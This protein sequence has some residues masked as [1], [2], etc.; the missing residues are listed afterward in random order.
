MI[1]SIL[2]ISSNFTGHGHKSIAESLCEK[3]SNNPNVEVHI[4]DGFSLGGTTL[5]NV[6]K[7]YG[8]ITRKSESL[9]ELIWDI[10]SVKPYL[11]NEI[12]ELKIK[13]RFLELLRNTKPD[14]ILSLHPNFN[15]SIVNILKKYH[16]KIPFVTLIADL[17]TISPL[18][19]DSR[20]DYIISPTTEAKDKCIEFGVP[21]EKIKVLGF[22]VRSRF[23]DHTYEAGDNKRLSSDSTLKCMIMSGGEGVGNMKKIAEILLNNFDCTVKIVAGRNKV[24]K[25]KLEKSLGTKYGNRVEIYGFTKNVQDLMECSD[26]AFTRGSPNVIMEAIACNVPLVITGALPG[27][28]EENPNFVEK[29]NL[30]VIC[31]DTGK[32]KDVISELTE[33]NL[34][35]LN[36]IR[37]FQRTY[38]NP[39]AAGNI[40]NFVLNLA[41]NADRLEARSEELLFLK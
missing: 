14:V 16:I 20:V 9:W 5:L 2:V 8:P 24:L 21:E 3:F 12:I 19:A 6:A 30:G 10:S 18:W 29:H 28:E 17:V 39:D 31:R 36:K 41:N 38:A 1:N 13:D 35:K 23:Y 25:N 11:I 34:Q 4:V 26:I 40:V 7:A 33:N 22:P 27:Q 15:G 32:I 37:R